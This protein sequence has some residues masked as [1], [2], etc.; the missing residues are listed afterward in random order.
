MSNFLAISTV[1]ATLMRILEQEVGSDVPGVMVTA[2]PLDTVTFNSDGL[3][4]FLYQVTWNNGYNNL[5]VPTR[6]SSGDIG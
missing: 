3:N 4:L 5:D 6:N 2:Q 1:T